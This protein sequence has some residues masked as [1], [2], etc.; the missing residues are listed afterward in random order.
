MKLL[1]VEDEI[2][3]ARRLQKMLRT[4]EPQSEVLHICDS[5]AAAEEWFANNP[6]PDLIFMDVQL[7]DGLCFDIFSRVRITAPVVFATAYDEYA[8]RAFKVN[9]I[10][11]LLKPIDNES[12]VAALNKYKQFHKDESDAGNLQ[13]IAQ[14]LI[15]RETAYRSRFLVAKGHR[16]IPVSIDDVAWFISEDKRVSLVTKEQHK[17]LLD[18]TLEQLEQ[19]LNPQQF[20]RANRQFIVS[21]RCV[22]SIENGFNGKL[23]LKLNPAPDET[24]TVSRDKA[25]EFL[26]W[27]GR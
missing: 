25:T 22:H 2:V 26:Q 1:I 5:I 19:E 15:N 6:Q 4:A 10:D 16:W 11:Y 27:L 12:L 14:S 3:A 17:Y 13:I 7:A 9:S 8:L 18:V 20:I 21:Q 24:V 23:H